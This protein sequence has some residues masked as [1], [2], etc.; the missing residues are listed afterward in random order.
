M[1]VIVENCLAGKFID[2]D[3][4]HMR[5]DGGLN[6]TARGSKWPLA[7]GD[8]V[9]AMDLF[10]G[11]S[12]AGTVRAVGQPSQYGCGDVVLDLDRGTWKD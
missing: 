9:I 11:G 10:N 6:A 4:H 5:I 7:V 8:K 12:C 1:G 2:V 3:F